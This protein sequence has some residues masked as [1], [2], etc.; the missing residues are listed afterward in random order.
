MAEAFDV[1]CRN[2]RV[3]P[4]D[5]LR[6]LFQPEWNLPTGSFKLDTL[7]KIAIKFLVDPSLNE[8]VIIRPDGM[9][10]V[11]GIGDIKAAGLSPEQLAKRIERKFIDANIFA[12]E[13]KVDLNNQKL[14]TVHVLEFYQKLAKLTQALTTIAGGQQSELTVAPDG[15]IDLPLLKRRILATGSTIPEIE[16]TIN[17]AY[18]QG[19]LEHVQVSLSLSEARSRKVY[20]LGQVKQPGAYEIKQPI[21]PMHAIAMAKGHDPDTA[22]LTS[23]ILVSKNIHGKP[24][25]RRLDLKRMLDIGDMSSAILVKPY[26]V[27]FVPKTYIRD[28]RLFMEQYFTTVSDFTQLYQS[29]LN[30]TTGS[31][32][33][34]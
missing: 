1:V 7:D 17:Q 25:G 5:K 16:R 14:V 24:I 19:V 11:Q 34:R 23:V 32:T 2:Y 6:M 22:D 9:I 20:V 4:D 31:G 29:L 33:G 12:R 27:I 13:I 18:S 10:T 3:G 26:D 28:V 15:S 30:N 8:D 21:T